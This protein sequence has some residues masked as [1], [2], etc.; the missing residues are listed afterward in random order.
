MKQRI[1]LWLA[2]LLVVFCLPASAAA[3]HHPAGNTV[4]NGM[5]TYSARDVMREDMQTKRAAVAEALAMDTADYV[6][7]VQEALPADA[8]TRPAYEK[9]AVR[10]AQVYA[11]EGGED[12]AE[13]VLHAIVLSA[14][15]YAGIPSGGSGAFGEMSNLIPAYLV[16]AYDLIYDSG[17]FAKLDETYSTDTR[18][19][20]E[21]YFTALGWRM[22]EENGG[23]YINNLGGY[24]IK[25]LAGTAYILGDPELIR[26]AIALLDDAFAPSQWYADGM[27]SEG[28]TSY[29]QQLMGN[30][31][32][33]VNVLALWDDPEGYTDDW[34]GL[35]LQHTDLKARW[36]II[37][38][39]QQVIAQMK[40]PN[41]TTLAVH[42]THPT[43]SADPEK[44]IQEA[45]LD[46]IE[47]NHFGLYALT[48]GT[49]EDAQQTSLVFPPVA[50]GIPYSGGHGHGNFLGLTYWAGGVE[51]LPDAGYPVSGSEPNRFFHMSTVTH[52][53]AWITPS[54][55]VNYGSLAGQYTRPTLLAYDDGT[56]SGGA[57]QL[58]EAR[59]LMPQ[60]QENEEN[61]R[62][63][64]TVAVDETHS[65]T[66]DVQRLRGGSVHEN[67]LRGSEDEAVSVQSD[68][69]VS[70]STPDLGATLQAE[71]KRG[72]MAGQTLFT[73]AQR[74]SAEADSH[75]VW[76]GQESGSS[77]HLFLKGVPEGE[78]ALSQMPGMRRDDV[79]PPHLYQRRSVS[80]ED[81]TVF[82]AVYEGTR[83]GESANVQGVRWITFDSNPA[84]AL[85]IVDLGEWEDWIY[86]SDS[87]A[88]QEY[89]GV[90]FSAGTAAIR[91]EKA[92]STPLWGY[93]Y[94]EGSI[95]TQDAGI[96]AG[97]DTVAQVTAAQGSQLTL[98]TALPQEVQGRWGMETFGDGTG[99]GH[100]LE[101]IQGNTVTLHNDAGYEIQPDGALHTFYPAR[102]EGGVLSGGGEADW[103]LPGAVTLRVPQT[104][105]G[106]LTPFGAQL[107][108]GDPLA[109]GGS[110]TVTASI[111]LSD[112]AQ[113]LTVVQRD[114]YADDSQ[115]TWQK[116]E[117]LTVAAVPLEKIGGELGSA[118][119]QVALPQELETKHASGRTASCVSIRA[120]VWNGDMAPLAPAGVW[121]ADSAG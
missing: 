51:L 11:A 95:C 114:F 39:A 117:V 67:F 28:T 94:G 77:L 4:Y 33:A 119:A 3:E 48:H 75:M 93:V 55:N 120:Y 97:A 24:A 92:S 61:R 100:R 58:V 46:N 99:L 26:C 38:A 82:G 6:Q 5:L 90:R 59:Q 13:K 118:Q 91:W 71:G 21:D 1:C 8:Y 29:G 104:A 87:T 30:C 78:Y 65:Y 81:T 20:V 14:Q 115:N 112:G 86:V 40:F 19:L 96:A 69:P 2:A 108:S 36:P 16:I 70:G 98:D 106:V 27:W 76:T 34:L 47:L 116:Q 54:Q 62:L 60:A 83:A 23:G 15:N 43:G 35:R 52:N 89:G 53:N 88:P 110:A 102:E 113:L 37:T 64:M 80:P 44:P 84:A 68:A 63:L 49:A 32:E 7:R 85:A 10:L 12:T 72:L 73:N 17:A 109:P 101:E 25:N 107:S 50:A 103:V 45:Y 56:A 41:G 57:V 79:N 74:G 31:L 105:F 9:E 111:P 42:D 121:Q 66:L 18:T 22:Y